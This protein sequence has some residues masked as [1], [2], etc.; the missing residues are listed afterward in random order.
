MPNAGGTVW[1]LGLLALLLSAAM[2]P[3][4]SPW[5][6]AKGFAL[7]AGGIVLAVWVFSRGDWP[8]SRLKAAVTA[9]VNLCVLGMLLDI[10]VSLARSP[11]P[12]VSRFEAMRYLGGAL[13]Y[14]A[15]VYG[16]A[17]RSSL[18]RGMELVALV[19][20]VAGI[21]AFITYGESGLAGEGLRLSGAFRN[22]QL[23][24]GFL[25]VTLPLVI[26]AAFSL[27][28]PLR[29]TGAQV[30]AVIVLGALL[31][32]RNRSAWLGSIAGL[33]ALGV[34]WWRFIRPAGLRVEGR[35]LLVPAIVLSLC[36]GAFVFAV[37]ESE[38]IARRTA[39]FSEPTATASVRWRQGMWEKAGRMIRDQP[40]TGHGIGLFPL[41]QALYYHPAALSR[42]QSQIAAT[43][44]GLSES[45]HNLYLQLAAEVGLPGLA[46]Y[47]ALLTA[48][49]VT[50][51]RALGAERSQ[52]RR[53]VGAGALAA[54]TAQ[55]VSALGSPA[56]EFPECSLFLWLTFG[57]GMS[58]A[59]LDRGLPS[60]QFKSTP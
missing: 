3:E 47:L 57:L 56:W 49:S 32:S 29:R 5:L 31:A 2:L 44:A 9:P 18:Q 35:L 25:C 30:A 23:L 51:I 58:A 42:T 28:A 1:I 52:F 34:L 54:V 50:S 20:G 40:L 53:W 15:T 45:A 43:G 55:A 38:L 4:R 33:A 48:F 24:G 21:V 37:P 59:R 41:Q 14:F 22:E 6:A 26:A 46:L 19:A 16:L 10:G 60:T 39:A 12:E 13:V 17:G 7:T 11:L 27:D 36:L 8:A